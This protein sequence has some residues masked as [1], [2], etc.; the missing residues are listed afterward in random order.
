MLAKNVVQKLEIVN[1]LTTAE[2]SINTNAFITSKKRPIVTTVSGRVK[3]IN[4]GLTIAFAKPR[5]RAAIK[6]E[7]LSAKRKPVKI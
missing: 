7:L 3:R 5:S 6:S 1:P 2:T 4:S